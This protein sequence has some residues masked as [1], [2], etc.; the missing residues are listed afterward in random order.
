MSAST[1]LLTEAKYATD[2]EQ[3]R[4][5]GLRLFA[6]IDGNN[7]YLSGTL[8]H[9]AAPLFFEHYSIN[10]NES[11]LSEVN[12]KA[13]RKQ[14]TWLDGVAISKMIVA[15]QNVHYKLLP[16]EFSA[17]QIDAQKLC[18][19]SSAFLNGKIVYGIDYKINIALQ[20][21]C[22]QVAIK[23]S[24]IGLLHQTSALTATYTDA[25]LCNIH[26]TAIDII[27]WQNSKVKMLNTFN[28]VTPEDIVYF[29][30]LA[31]QN[32]FKKE[33]P[34]LL[35]G[36]EIIQQSK[37]YST[38]GKFFNPLDMANRVALKHQGVYKTLAPNRFLSLSGIIACE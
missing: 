3:L 5:A 37:I 7:F 11:F 29:I 23:H 32:H 4:T 35:I 16:F 31:I 17:S 36:G 2:W 15:V 13:V 25:V 21:F 9:D 22:A 6:E 14:L 26:A 20:S 12:I 24:M 33:A 38:I 19:D 27:V 18:S 10:T 28:I 8:V 34:Q 30:Q 1:I